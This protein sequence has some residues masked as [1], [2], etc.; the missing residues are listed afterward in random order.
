MKYSLR[1]ALQTRVY[2]DEPLLAELQRQTDEESIV[3]SSILVDPCHF[4]EAAARLAQDGRP[5]TCVYASLM[6]GAIPLPVGFKHVLVDVVRCN[7]TI[8]VILEAA[9][10]WNDPLFYDNAVRCL[11]TSIIVKEAVMAGSILGM[12]Q[13]ALQNDDICM[14]ERS[15]WIK[16]VDALIGRANDMIH[17]FCPD[18]TSKYRKGRYA[19]ASGSCRN[20]NEFVVFYRTNRQKTVN[21]TIA[22]LLCARRLGL[23]RD[24]ACLIGDL[25][26]RAVIIY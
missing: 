3:I 6:T 21:A 24:V 4:L 9:R 14:I 2:F 17:H 13:Y 20:D 16:R 1:F 19:F 18:D 23:Y 8:D 25:V 15:V 11:P 10:K 5:I 22:W 12:R 26:N 7:A